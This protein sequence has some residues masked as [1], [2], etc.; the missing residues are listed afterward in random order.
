MHH[1]SMM[2]M[3][4]VMMVM[5]VVMVVMV[6]VMGHRST[7]GMIQAHFNAGGITS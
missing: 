5:M 6:M 4:M 1:K 2:M 3:M 7:L